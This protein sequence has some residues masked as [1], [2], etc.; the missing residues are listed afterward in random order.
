METEIV[1]PDQIAVMTLPDV[2]FFPQALMPLYIF[3]PRYRLMLRDVLQTHRLF[4]L[5]GL[6]PD[7]DPSEERGHRIATAGI[8]RAS[9][10]NPDGTS[11]LLIQGIARVECHDI[12]REDPYRVVNIKALTSTAGATDDANKK[13]RRRVERLLSLKRK[14]GGEIPDGFTQFLR[15]VD[16]S[17]TFVDLAAFTLCEKSDLKQKLLETLDVH[18]RLLLYSRALRAEVDRLTLH[19][20]LQGSLA[21]ED[22]A[23]N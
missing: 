10:Q 6:D 13:L 21:D 22:I 18:K 5:A 20:R 15:T 9:N 1:V 11:N 16:D 7:S 4:A 14:L 23:N 3:E 12:V 8:V 2:A 19:R 17:E